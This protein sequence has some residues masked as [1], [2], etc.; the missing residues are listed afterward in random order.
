MVALVG[1]VVAL[2]AYMRIPTMMYMRD[3]PD[4]EPTEASTSELAVLLLCAVAT[5]YLGVAPDSMLPG[6]SSH[7]LEL[8]E[9]LVKLPS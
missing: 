7:L 9:G 8:L 5:V 1:S 4:Q 6:L 3:A 2:Y